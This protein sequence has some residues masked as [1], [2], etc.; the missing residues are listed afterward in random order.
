MVWFNDWTGLSNSYDIYVRCVDSTGE[1][2]SW[3]CVSAGAGGEFLDRA[4][5]SLAFNAADREYLGVYML[6]FSD[7]HTL[8]KIWG[9]RV[10]RDGSWLG[11][12]VQIFA[13][14]N[15]DFGINC[16]AW[17]NNRNEYLVVASAFDT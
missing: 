6:D 8:S 3:F 4:S 12:E 5:P 15:R 11:P 13:W 9:R 14:T 7:N 16:V 1:L 10:A 17:N 2:P